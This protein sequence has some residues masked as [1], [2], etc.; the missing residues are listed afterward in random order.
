[1][2][3]MGNKP[4]LHVSAI[5]AKGSRSSAQKARQRTVV[6]QRR[7]EKDENQTHRTRTDLK[8]KDAPL[9]EDSTVFRATDMFLQ[10]L[11]YFCFGR[12]SSSF[13]NSN[14]CYSYLNKILRRRRI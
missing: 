9:K 12:P 8:R 6:Q 5:R 13:S 1:M 11:I 7:E 3:S 4:N 2:D 10:Q 14:L